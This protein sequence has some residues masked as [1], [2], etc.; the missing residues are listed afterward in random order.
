MLALA[1]ALAVSPRLIIADE[2]SLGLAPIVVE[3]VFDQ[4]RAIRNRGITVVII[5]QF[6]NRALDLAD[7]CVILAHG[8]V[9]WEGAP[10]ETSAQVLDRYLGIASN[11][12]G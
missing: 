2:L 10:A 3:Q 7:H 5:E 9:V 11:E 1:R 4:L 6:I 12:Q 8:E